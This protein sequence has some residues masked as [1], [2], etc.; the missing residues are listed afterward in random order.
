MM[1]R[2]NK[3]Q[4]DQEKGFI[5][6]NGLEIEKIDRMRENGRERKRHRA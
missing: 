5:K 2:G 1:K 3:I 4:R 6:E